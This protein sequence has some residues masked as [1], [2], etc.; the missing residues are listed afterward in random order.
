M[1]FRYDIGL[2]RAIAVLAVLLYHYE[3]PGF[4]GGF[5]GVDIFFVISGFLM[6]QIVLSGMDKGVFSYKKFITK[7]IKRIVPALLVVSACLLLFI[8]FFYFTSDL[9]LN[10]KYIGLG[11]SFSSNNYYAFRSG[12]YFSPDAIDNIFL[13]TWTLAVEMQFYVLYPLLLLA[14]RKVYLYKFLQFRFIYVGLTLLSFLLCMYW[15]K[16]KADYAFYLMPARGWE[17][18]LGGLAFLYTKEI[19]GTLNRVSSVLLYGLLMLLICS[20]IGASGRYAWPSLFALLP[21]LVTALILGLGKEQTWLRNRGIQFLGNISYSLYL[22]HWPVYVLYRKY[23]F[24]FPHKFSS[25][26]P[27]LLSVVLASLSYYWVEKNKEQMNVRSLRIAFPALTGLAVLLYLGAQWPL[28]ARI[29]L[30]GTEYANYFE[31]DE[32]THLNPCNC[33]ITD[34]KNYNFFDADQCLAVDSAKQ[35]ILLMGDS[36]AAELSTAFRKELNKNQRL[37]EISLSLSFPFPN[38]RGYAKS[39]DLWRYFYKKYLPENYQHI[40]KIFVSVHWLMY[41]YEGMNYTKEEIRQGVGQMLSIFEQYGLDYYFIGQTEEYLL[42]YHK[43]ALKMK[44]NKI[45]DESHYVNPVGA[46]VNSYLKTIIPKGRYIAIYQLKEL[47]HDSDSL[48]GPYMFDTHHLS[49]AG[50]SQVINY[51]KQKNYF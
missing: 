8:P 39:V 5:I 20:I 49:P 3:I 33:Y 29:R 35:N 44:T 21:T 18:M 23:E 31:Y 32:H 27:I 10:A 14:L 42:P 24:A 6:T 1:T 15:L 46:R 38:P 13:H 45:L 7:R 36:H 41:H 28:W 48:G 30:L 43:V 25:L 26:V 16:N 22:W 34:S 19:R 47:V 2:L 11:L 12:A 37:Q 9:R 40:D 17:F 50:A 4:N 51:L